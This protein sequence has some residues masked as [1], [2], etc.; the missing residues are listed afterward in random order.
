MA[1]CRSPPCSS[2]DRHSQEEATTADF[3]TIFFLTLFCVFYH[4][5]RSAL[6][7]LFVLISW[8]FHNT[9]ILQFIF[10]KLGPTVEN[11]SKNSQSTPTSAS[12]RPS[13]D[14]L[15]KVPLAISRPGFIIASP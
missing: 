5:I 13:I 14:G 11:A 7:T 12:S 1:R 10:S 3:L 6:H 8:F 4:H 9:P 15:L 2:T